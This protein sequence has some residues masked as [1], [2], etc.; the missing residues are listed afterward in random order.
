MLYAFPELLHGVKENTA[1][2]VMTNLRYSYSF[3]MFV[4]QYNRANLFLPFMPGLPRKLKHNSKHLPYRSPC[5]VSLN[6][7]WREE[8][9]ISFNKLSRKIYIILQ[10]DRARASIAIY[11]AAVCHNYSLKSKSFKRKRYTSRTYINSIIALLHRVGTHSYIVL[12]V[13]WNSGISGHQRSLQALHE[14]KIVFIP[15]HGKM[16]STA[17]IS[18]HSE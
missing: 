15:I 16:L 7:A 10:H 12:L 11:I 5:S 8:T 13:V 6:A 1:F 9:S 17:T 2:H 3:K 18:R 4:M 14:V